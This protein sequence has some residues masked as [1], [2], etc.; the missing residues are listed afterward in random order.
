[1]WNHLMHMAC[2]TL[3]INLTKIICLSLY[4]DHS[5]D[6][7]ETENATNVERTVF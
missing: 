2:D 4:M 3:E 6:V 5:T 7:K 1:M